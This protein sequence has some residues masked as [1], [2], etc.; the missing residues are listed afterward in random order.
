MNI[1]IELLTDAIFGSGVSIPG[2]ED[3]SILSDE[4]GFPY[5]RGST[6]KGMIREAMVNYLMWTNTQTKESID[7]LLGKS[8]IDTKPESIRKIAVSDFIIPEQVRTLVW[9]DMKEKAAREA[10]LDL[11][12][13]MRTFTKIEEDTAKDGSLRTCRCITK[14]LMFYGT[15]EC[16]KE[17]EKFLLN[18]LSCV[19]WIGSLSTRGFGKVKITEVGGA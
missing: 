10:I 17:D 9:E 3:I 19:K 6:M 2:G 11:Y 13:F 16:K 12:S 15:I 8:G 1:K 4:C 5:L 18:V 7:E 14:G